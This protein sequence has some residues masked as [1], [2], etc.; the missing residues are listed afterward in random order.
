MKSNIK[1]VS[2]GGSIIIPKTGFDT[3][4]LKKFRQMIIDEVK[5]GQKFI[6]IIG[7]GSTARNYQDALKGTIKI[8]ETD[9]DW[10]GIEATIIN[11][12]F[13]RLM[14][15]ELA[16]K[17][18]I[19]NPT[20]KI[21]TNKSIIVAAGYKPGCSTDYDAVLFAKT[22]G[23]IEVLNLSNIEYVYDKDPK[24]FSDA[25]KIENIDWKTFRKEIVGDIW[26]PGKSAPFDPVASKAAEKLKLKVSI[27][28]GTNL[29]EV[30]KAL[31]G[32]KFR[33]TVIE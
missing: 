14:F 17:D 26:Q 30:K 13:V 32:K 5:K 28:Q 20:K 6:L 1:I 29:L 2:V 9:L 31:G 33:G 23:A 18:V 21:K 8:S 10:M 4:F 27:L 12:N 19:T 16:Y 24:E 7:G 25:K 15:G 3:E 11:A 22:Y